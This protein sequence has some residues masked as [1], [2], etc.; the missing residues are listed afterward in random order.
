[1]RDHKLAISYIR[2]SSPQQAR[3]DSRRRQTEAAEAYCTRNGLILTDE[4]R[5]QDE[6]KSAYKGLH[7]KATSALG[8]LE[9]QLDSGNIPRGTVLIIENLDRL[10][11]QDVVIAQNL[12]TGL[13]IK[14][15][16]IVVL[17]DNER[18]YTHESAAANPIELMLSV[19]IAGRAYEESRIKS[20]RSK[21]IWVNRRKQASAGKA[22]NMRL[23]PWLEYKSGKY[24]VIE[25]SADVV[26]R[27]YKL[28]LEGYGTVSIA[29]ILNK[30]NVPNIAR[31]ER[32]R[33]DKWDC[34]NVH[35]IL[36]FKEVIG[37]YT[38]ASLEVPN[39]FPPIISD[40]DYY[41][42]QT[43]QKERR[44]YKGQR[45]EKIYIFSHLWKCT[46]CGHGLT[47][48]TK[49]GY[50]YVMCMGKINDRCKVKYI[51]NP[52]FE[53]ALLSCIYS[54]SPDLVAIDNK[55]AAKA[56]E[57]LLAEKGRIVELTEKIETAAAMVRTTPS[58]AGFKI[59]QEMEEQRKAIEKRIELIHSAVY[60][61]DHRK[62]WRE[63]KTRLEAELRAKGSILTVI[64]VTIKKIGDKLEYIRHT[65]EDQPPSTIA[66]RELLR[67]YIERIAVDI[68]KKEATIMFKSGKSI[69]MYF[70]SSNTY[71]RQYSYRTDSSDWIA[72]DFKG[73]GRKQV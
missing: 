4:F 34:A 11:R 37:Y 67:A 40:S 52:P 17:S 59:V 13:L 56:H 47:V 38:G 32:L 55:T 14:G 5:L 63:V 22:V 68:P 9:K 24:V 29:R 66:I 65:E 50:S 35:R 48:N 31:Q 44:K 45:S 61:A 60:V 30:D 64:P 72:I 62:D 20:Y 28:Y 21:A 7:R 33:A 3:G 2:F 19:M 71:P 39:F 6:G 46:H 15:L 36:N 27:I 54:A 18:R 26:K 16:E 42:A 51:S 49:D 70:R 73:P 58:E 41:V 23:K 12:L 43:K 1:M 53:K 8:K 10:T 69:K 57:E 25:K